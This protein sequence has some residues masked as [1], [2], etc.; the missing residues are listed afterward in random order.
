MEKEDAVVLRGSF[1]E[2]RHAEFLV[3]II[4]DGEH[5]VLQF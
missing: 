1:A 3:A 5:G 4:G 2:E